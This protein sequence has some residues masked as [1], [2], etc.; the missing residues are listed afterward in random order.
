[1]PAAKKAPKKVAFG[2]GVKKAI[3]KVSCQPCI[4]A[5]SYRRALCDD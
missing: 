1:M 3:K 2:A 5:P 4:S